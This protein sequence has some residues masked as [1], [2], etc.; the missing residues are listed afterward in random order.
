L[1]LAASW[2]SAG[3]IVGYDVTFVHQVVDLLTS[4]VHNEPAVPSFVDGLR[5]QEAIA[6][7]AREERW[8]KLVEISGG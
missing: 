6:R 8:A 1:A 5:V 4:I 2:W 7:S 3:R